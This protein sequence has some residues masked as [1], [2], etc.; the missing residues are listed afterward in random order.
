MNNTA[1]RGKHRHLVSSVSGNVGVNKSSCSNRIAAQMYSPVRCKMM[2][3][4]LCLS[5]LGGGMKSGFTKG[6]W[7]R[8]IVKLRNHIG[9]LLITALNWV[10]RRRSVWRTDVFLGSLL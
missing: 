3:E 8:T 6:I 1:H 2:P 10:I 4:C 5:F 9:M 7:M